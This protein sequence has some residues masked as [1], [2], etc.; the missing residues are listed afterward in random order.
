M[1]VWW[2]AVR[3][4]GAPTSLCLGALELIQSHLAFEPHLH[5]LPGITPSILKGLLARVPEPDALVA[6]GALVLDV[7]HQPDCPN[8]AEL[9]EP[10]RGPCRG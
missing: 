4:C 8:V 2:L 1:P 7:D 9:E 10:H 5:Q 3:C 6:H